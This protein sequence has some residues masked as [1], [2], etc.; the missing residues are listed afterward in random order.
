MGKE[1]LFDF[2][3][4]NINE[5]IDL[6]EFDFMRDWFDTPS[7]GPI[8]MMNDPSEFGF[9]GVDYFSAYEE[10]DGYNFE[11]FKADWDKYNPNVVMV[12]YELE[13]IF[14]TDQKLPKLFGN[15]LSSND[16]VFFGWV[17]QKEAFKEYVVNGK[18]LYIVFG[19]PDPGSN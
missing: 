4:E 12:G 15:T 3:Q 16:L 14:I 6:S 2:V 5:I 1:E 19:I 13:T 8:S 9:N 18:T 7:G 10:T 17:N 11:A